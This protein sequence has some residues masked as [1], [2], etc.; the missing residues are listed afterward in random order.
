MQPLGQRV[1]I[2]DVGVL[3]TVKKHVHAAD[4][5]H[6]VVEVETMEH[7]V[8]EVL[9]QLLVMQQTWMVLA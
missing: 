6:R 7:A 9:A 4:A 1:P 5:K 2:P 8:V 3:D